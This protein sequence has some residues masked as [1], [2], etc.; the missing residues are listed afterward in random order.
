[1]RG[2]NTKIFKRLSVNI[3]T[4][5]I[6]TFTKLLRPYMLNFPNFFSYYEFPYPSTGQIPTQTSFEDD[7]SKGDEF[8][9]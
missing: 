1:M 8:S 7:K 2:D 9:L 4:P 5:Y 3:P 6:R